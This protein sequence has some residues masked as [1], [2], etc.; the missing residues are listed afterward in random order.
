MVSH[1]MIRVSRNLI[2]MV[3]CLPSL[4]RVRRT[5]ALVLTEGTR[6]DSLSLKA[7]C[8]LR[9]ASDSNLALAGGRTQRLWKSEPLN[10]RERESWNRITFPSL[11]S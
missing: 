3:F 8:A 1:K 5:V 11:R 7:E 2:W 4:G 10:I 6:N 9:P